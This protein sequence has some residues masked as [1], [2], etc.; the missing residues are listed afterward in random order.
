[1]RPSAV[2]ALSAICRVEVAANPW[3]AKSSSA[4]LWICS[5]RAC[6]RCWR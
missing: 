2:P 1:M 3:Q 4:T 6:A 5:T